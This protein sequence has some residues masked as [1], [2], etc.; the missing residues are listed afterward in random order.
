MKGKYIITKD[1]KPI[2]IPNFVSH[3]SIISKEE[4]QSAGF[5]KLN[6]GKFVCYGRSESLNID[7]Q[8]SDSQILNTFYKEAVSEIK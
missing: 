5:F 2:L 1:L 3:D 4:I 8:F 6:L 7:S